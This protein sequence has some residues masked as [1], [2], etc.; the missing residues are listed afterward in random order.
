ML[1]LPPF[2]S[3]NNNLFDSIFDDAADVEYK[4]TVARLFAEKAAAK[5][6]PYFKKPEGVPVRPFGVLFKEASMLTIQYMFV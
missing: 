3:K 1:I 5:S 2:Q 4:P 6:V